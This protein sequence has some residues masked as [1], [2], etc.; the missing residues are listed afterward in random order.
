[1]SEPRI[2]AVSCTSPGGLHRMA[3]YEWGDADNP[4]VVVCV[5]GLT[6][7]G[8]DFD[9][10]AQA[11]ASRF[12][13]VCP[14]VVGRGLSDW[15]P[16]PML[17][18]V[19]QYV[20][21]MVTLIARL[22]P[23]TLR[24]VGTSMGGLI[25][26]GLAGAIAQSRSLSDRRPPVQ[27][28]QS[29]PE[30]GM[31][32]HRMVINDVGPRIEPVSLLRIGQYL[33]EPVAF[34]SFEQ[35]VDYVK[36]VSTSFGQLSDE[37]WREFTRHVYVKVD[38]KWIKHYDP[39]IAIP[40]AT[41]S[42]EVTQQGEQALW[43]AWDAMDCPVLVLRGQE[44]DLLSSNTLAEMLRR[45][46]LSRARSFSGVGHAPSLMVPDQIGAVTEFLNED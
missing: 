16:M 21:D 36:T 37:L 46:P 27:G 30:T 32:L 23:A 35:A 12:R 1:M 11:L 41:V 24:W 2:H 20:A 33:A 38:G 29:L 5:H 15:L 3:Y 13:V 8:R 7:S 43:Q 18:V 44:S 25:G 34:D 4:D 19:P 6:R 26:L 22:R 42:P 39:T 31:R 10:L 28:R 14:D 17:Y 40:F 45:Q 9:R